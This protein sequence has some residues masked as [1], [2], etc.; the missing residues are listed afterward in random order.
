V[1][2]YIYTHSCA[3]P[4]IIQIGSLFAVIYFAAAAGSERNW[5]SFKNAVA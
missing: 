2:R 5:G 4:F 3:L 1:C